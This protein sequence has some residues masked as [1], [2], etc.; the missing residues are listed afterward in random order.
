MYHIHIFPFSDRVYVSGA[1]KYNT[2]EVDGEKVN[3]SNII[4]GKEMHTHLCKSISI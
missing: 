3:S 4:A 2:Y 1:I